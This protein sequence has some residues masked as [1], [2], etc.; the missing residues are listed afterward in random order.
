MKAIVDTSKVVLLTALLGVAL[1]GCERRASDQASGAA[2]TSGTTTAPS[3]TAATSDST[4]GASGTITAPGSSS[5]MAG[6]TSGTTSG[7]AGAAGSSADTGTSGTTASGATGAATMSGSDAGASGSS[8][9]SGTSTSSGASGTT[10]TGSSVGAVIDDSIITT[11]VKAALLADPDV[12]GTDINVETKK[13][14][15]MLSGFVGNQQQIDQAMKI[16]KAVE[17]VKKVDNKMTV[18]Q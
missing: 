3:G 6:T 16:A 10:G 8:D 7:T 18:K 9:T 11:K 15:V 13:G 14:E 2:G 4:T 12:K 5:S 17:G 1:A